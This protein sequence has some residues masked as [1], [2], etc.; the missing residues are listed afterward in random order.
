MGTKRAIGYVRVSTDGQAEHGVS[1]DAQREGIEQRAGA[2]GFELTDIIAESASG[3]DLAHR[4]GMMR[5]IDL[6]RGGK[7]KAVFVA[8]VD[9]AWRNTVDALTI[10]EAFQKRGVKLYDASGEYRLETP[11][12]WFR[13]TIDA[14]LAERERRVIGYRTKEALDHKR[15]RGERVG[16]FI[17]FGYDLAADGVHLIENPEEQAIIRT[18]EELRAAGHSLRAIADELTLQGFEPKNG[19]DA[20]SHCTVSKILGRAA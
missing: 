6:A 10:A 15:E 4:P 12:D 3:K 20:W 9:R 18:I 19:G 7:V 16:R 11:D 17:T 2:M 8:K 1:L 5:V 13:F 14:A